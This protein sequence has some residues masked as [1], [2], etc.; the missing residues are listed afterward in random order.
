[1]SKVNRNTLGQLCNDKD[2][3]PS[4]TTMQKVM[5]VVRKH[6]PRKQVTDFWSM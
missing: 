4:P 5:K 1:M 3:L 2:Y 6:E